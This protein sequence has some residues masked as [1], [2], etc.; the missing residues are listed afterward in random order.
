MNLYKNLNYFNDDKYKSLF[1]EI[2]IGQF[3]WYVDPILL[4]SVSEF[5]C[6]Y[7]LGSGNIPPSER[8]ELD[9][10]LETFKVVMDILHNYP[11]LTNK[12]RFTND[13]ILYT[14]CKTY[15]F[16]EVC[17]VF[18]VMDMLMIDI[19]KIIEE[20][21]LCANDEDDDDTEYKYLCL[22]TKD[23]LD[24]ILSNDNPQLK[25]MKLYNMDK[26]YNRYWKDVFESATIQLLEESVRM[27][28]TC[29]GF[30]PVNILFELLGEECFC[31]F[32]EGL[33]ISGEEM[34]DYI[35]CECTKKYLIYKGFKEKI[36]D[37][38]REC[39][40]RSN[41]K[42]CW[43]YLYSVEEDLRERCILFLTYNE[44]LKQKY[45][46][47]KDICPRVLYSQDNSH[48]LLN[49]RPPYWF[50]I[51][52]CDF[53]YELAIQNQHLYENELIYK[54]YNEDQNK[55]RKQM[56]KDVI[57]K[58][59]DNKKDTSYIEILLELMGFKAELKY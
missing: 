52:R 17:Q 38:L 33:S 21:Y 23:E 26:R 59:K 39:I 54:A 10:N 35:T 29:P 12:I 49:V 19:N 18:S 50:M 46:I 32:L 25:V 41:N 4:C 44:D 24:V 7:F 34:M 42:D 3:S 51:N 11:F 27:N 56:Y 28:N 57:S 37:I 16:N 2:K 30:I 58:Y 22:P 9:T 6:A 20:H 40:T 1:R 13:D 53:I 14:V 45:V 43:R 15:S 55:E 5:W 36:V 47:D 31:Q 48:I 8:Y